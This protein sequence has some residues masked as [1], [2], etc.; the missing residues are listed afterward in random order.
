[1][2]RITTEIDEVTMLKLSKRAERAGMSI[3]RAL[4]IIATKGVDYFLR[5]LVGATK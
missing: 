4:Q 2:A 3:P 1:M 5:C